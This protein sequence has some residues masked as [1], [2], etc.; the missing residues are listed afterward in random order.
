MSLNSLNTRKTDVVTLTSV[1]SAFLAGDAGGGG[2]AGGSSE[3][4]GQQ[5]KNTKQTYAQESKW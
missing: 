5:K 1:I 4:C 2:Q 3:T